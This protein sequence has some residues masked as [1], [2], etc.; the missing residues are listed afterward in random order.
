MN[1]K[2]Q[3]LLSIGVC[4]LDRAADIKR[5]LSS[6]AACPAVGR[7][8]ILLVNNGCGE[9]TRSVAGT[10]RARLNLVYERLSRRSLGLARNRCL[11]MARADL[12]AYVDDDSVVDSGWL[13][14]ILDDFRHRD[15]SIVGQTGPVFPLV[16]GGDLPPWIPAP[17]AA[18]AFSLQDRGNLERLLAG[19]QS[20]IGNNMVYRT[21]F[22]REIGG[23][24]HDLQNYDEAYVCWQALAAGKA[25]IYNPA[26]RS[27]HVVRKDR[28]GAEWMLRKAR[29]QGAAY[30]KLLHSLHG[31]IDTPST[32]DL[33]WTWPKPVL[34]YALWR[35]LRNRPK[36]FTF[37][38]MTTFWRGRFDE[39]AGHRG[40]DDYY[41]R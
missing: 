6:L 28:L 24:H 15:N 27:L 40:E 10:Q 13:S 25:L 11:Q 17:V 14:S 22:L 23:F 12:L 29:A 32:H 8:Q 16:D 30:Q 35:L 38:Y 19:R 26:M 36:A 9:T 33:W 39:Y 18:S 2:S 5:L 20:L 4:T 41:E 31:R 7:C 3:P 34:G 21:G 1:D 37:Q